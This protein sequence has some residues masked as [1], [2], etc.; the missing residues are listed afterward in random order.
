M[1]SILLQV[2]QIITLV[3]TIFLV[4]LSIY[5]NPRYRGNQ[6]F[7]LSLI[8]FE[9]F[10]L[11]F[12]IYY[13]SMNE[14]V[15]QITLRIAIFVM[16]LGTFLFVLAIQIFVKSDAFIK[17]KI[18]KISAFITFLIL[19]A[20]VFHPNLVIVISLNPTVT[21]RSLVITILSIGW[22]FIL[23]GYNLFTLFG[24]LKSTSGDSKEFSKKLKILIVG[25][26]L[27]FIIPV[28]CVLSGLMALS[29]FNLGSEI[30]SIVQYLSQFAAFGVLG[31]AFLRK[32]SNS[33]T[34]SENNDMDT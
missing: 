9:I 7:A 4:G 6:L 2:I 34:P 18:A 23:T 19:M 33:E 27:L 12:V 8:F 30:F 13:S 31:F 14:I 22:L 5:R 32:K 10:V 21:Q 20:T 28:L 11:C 3:W 24:M 25:Q 26:I 16:I 15:V 29:G 17:H 1:V